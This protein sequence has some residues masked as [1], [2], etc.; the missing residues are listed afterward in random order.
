MK[1][2]VKKHGKGIIVL[3]DKSLKNPIVVTGISRFAKSR[4]IPY[5]EALLR[6]AS[7]GLNK[8]LAALPDE[9]EEEVERKIVEE[10]AKK[11]REAAGRGQVE[12]LDAEELERSSSSEAQQEAKEAGKLSKDPKVEQRKD[13]CIIC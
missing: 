6:L 12:E 11:K 4:G 5:S 7:M 2:F 10:A 13:G 9:V 1:K 8:I 3:V